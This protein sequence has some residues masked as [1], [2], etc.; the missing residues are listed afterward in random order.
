[1]LGHP[2]TPPV[3]TPF[4]K[5]FRKPCWS[6][7]LTASA[8]LPFPGP[9][10]MQPWEAIFWHGALKKEVAF[11]AFCAGPEFHNIGLTCANSSISETPHFHND[12][13]LDGLAELREASS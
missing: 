8:N 1:M 12:C 5:K 4:K 10:W 9:C 2:P 3:Q 6:P 13:K 11:G 7:I